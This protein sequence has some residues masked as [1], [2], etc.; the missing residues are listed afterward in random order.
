MEELLWNHPEKLLNENLRQFRRQPSSQVGRADLVFVDRIERIL[1]VEL[2]RGVLPRGAITQLV[3]Y[4]GMLKKEFPNRAVELMVV[5]NTIPQ[6]RAL[7]CLQ[8][9]IEPREISEKKFRDVAAEVGFVF[10]SENAISTSGQT[11]EIK[12]PGVSGLP[13]GRKK[14]GRPGF[15][16][17]K[18]WRYARSFQGKPAFLAFVNQLGSCSMRV[19]DAVDGSFLQKQYQSGD[20][21]VSFR[22][23]MIESVP[24]TVNRPP[25]LDKACKPKLPSLVLSELRRQIA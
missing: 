11:L 22:P 18:E 17:S 9:N 13:P 20:Y 2:K 8:F 14:V 16:V 23:Q 19:F 6:E 15:K 24:V 7:A 12:E 5:A 10:E 4:F 3:D 25:N 21:E 1:V